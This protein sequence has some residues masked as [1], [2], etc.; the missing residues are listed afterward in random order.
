ML[1]GNKTLDWKLFADIKDALMESDLPF[2]IDL[3]DYHTVPEHFRDEINNG[4]V[5]LP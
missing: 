3:L 5:I 2:R 4:E 1:C